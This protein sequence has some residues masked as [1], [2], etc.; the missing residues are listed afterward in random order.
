MKVLSS[1]IL[2]FVF[3]SCDSQIKKD[4]STIDM[5]NYKV[6][7]TIKDHTEIPR[8]DT[9]DYFVKKITNLEFIKKDKKNISE[10]NKKF[11]DFEYQIKGIDNSKSLNPYFI[12]QAGFANTYRFEV[13]HIIYCFPKE[14]KV[15]LYDPIKDSLIY[16][17]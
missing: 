15:M 4:S 17:K 9:V 3:F 16:L 1:I 5:K 6:K 13:Y 14:N 8:D 12:V 11:T 2:L 7:A 10:S